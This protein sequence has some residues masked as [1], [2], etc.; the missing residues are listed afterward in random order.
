MIFRNIY[1]VFIWYEFILWPNQ[2]RLPQKDLGTQFVLN[3]TPFWSM[4]IVMYIIEF[5]EICCGSGRI[6]TQLAMW[7]MGAYIALYSQNWNVYYSYMGLNIVFDLLVIHN[8][9]KW[10]HY[11][12][13][14]FSNYKLWGN[15]QVGVKRFKAKEGNDCLVFYPV[16]MGTK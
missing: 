2:L 13:E 12:Q 6:L 3:K 15:Y 9:F 8:W 10:I 14:D 1:A 11:R 5:A 16:D 4:S 7:W